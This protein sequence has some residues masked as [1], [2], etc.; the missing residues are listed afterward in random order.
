MAYKH[1]IG[2]RVVRDES[3]AN[4]YP[5]PRRSLPTCGQVPLPLD[6]KYRECWLQVVAPGGRRARANSR[7]LSVKWGARSEVAT[8]DFALC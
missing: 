1:M 3:G 8:L 7:A 2:R 5:I 4:P 6:P